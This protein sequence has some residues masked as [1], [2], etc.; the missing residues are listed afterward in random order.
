MLLRVVMLWYIMLDLLRRDGRIR[1][2]HW[3]TFAECGGAVSLLP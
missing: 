2:S 3:L 1:R